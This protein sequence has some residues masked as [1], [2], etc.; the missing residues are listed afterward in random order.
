MSELFQTLHPDEDKMGVRID[1]TKYDV[2]RKTILGI[3]HRCGRITFSELA[4]QVR[5]QLNGKFDGSVMWYYTTVK[6][7][8]EMRGEIRRVPGSRRQLLESARN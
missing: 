2:M 3:V 4:A 1:K 7:D 6:L 5:E 8:L